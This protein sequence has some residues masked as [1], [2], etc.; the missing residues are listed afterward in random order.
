L[1]SGDEVVDLVDEDDRVVEVVTRAELRARG[2][3]ARHR[4]VYVA[5]TTSAG[6]LVVH[7][8]ADWK[9]VYPG[10]WDVCFGG[11][12]GAGERWD[13]A[14]RRELAEEAGIDAE[15]RLVGVATW[16]AADTRLNARIYRVEHDG[17]YTCPD[18]EVVEVAT[19]ALA[20][21]PAW[22]ARRSVCPDTGDH[23]LPH[24]A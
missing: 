5:V 14:A 20:D 7:R 16:G 1:A 6:A 11:V 13:D 8:R 12:L 21:L 18:G 3:A 22:L 4:A 2:A 9:D 19:V 10:Y 23:V 15:P 24:L 17:P